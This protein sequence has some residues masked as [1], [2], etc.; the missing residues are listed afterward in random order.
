[1]GDPNFLENKIS[2]LSKV[3]NKGEK[4][5]I[6]LPNNVDDSHSKACSSTCVQCAF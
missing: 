4:K 3:E 5:K 1:M 6:L 2:G